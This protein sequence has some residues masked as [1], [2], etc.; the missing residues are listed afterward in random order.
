[1]SSGV[2]IPFDTSSQYRYGFT[3]ASFNFQKTNIRAGGTANDPINVN[4]DNGTTELNAYF[5][6]PPDGQPGRLD[7]LN[8]P[9]LFNGNPL[10]DGAFENDLVIHEN[11]HGVSQRM[12]GGGTTRCLQTIE[13]AGLGEGWSD[14]LADWFNQNSS[15]V[16]DFTF[17][18]KYFGFVAREYTYSV[19][20]TVNPQNYS[21]AGT[22]TEPHSG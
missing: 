1:M 4:V 17:G 18:G 19:N 14:A 5:T 2:V 11:G 7:L 15:T 10:H 8:W 22:S 12:T 9:S 6:A 16:H 13:S 21:W 20:F 3:E